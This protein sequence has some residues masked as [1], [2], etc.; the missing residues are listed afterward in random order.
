MSPL[1]I[2]AVGLLGFVLWRQIAALVLAS[3]VM[4]M[5]LGVVYTVQ[6][7]GTLPRRLLS[8]RS[9]T[10]RQGLFVRPRR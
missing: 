5:L 8:T 4:L 9:Q 1:L 2:L 10:I 6:L 3:L 7:A